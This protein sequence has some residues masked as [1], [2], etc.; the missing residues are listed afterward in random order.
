MIDVEQVVAGTLSSL[1]VR[2]D[3]RPRVRIETREGA[4]FDLPLE[5][6]ERLG[7]GQGTVVDE[8]ERER[9]RMLVRRHNAARDADT[10]LS[11]RL[12][13]RRELRRRLLAKGHEAA[14][15]D[16]L[17]SDLAERALL[18]DA[19]MARAFARDRIRLKPRGA[20]TI[21]AELR[22]RG[23]SPD[24][25]RSAVSQAFVDS[26]V[27]ERDLARSVADHWWATRGARSLERSGLRKTRERL[28]AHLA[29][30]GF[31]LDV[32]RLVADDVSACQD[33]SP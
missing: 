17:L 22:E 19:R 9:A 3:R 6:L 8:A 29:R 24:E 12:R 30:R 16:T 25:A 7:W 13:S 28:M 32:A 2:R 26:E 21:E 15:V 5:V 14:V 18:D 20:R 33:L 31:P 27:C 4:S 10:L 1:E 11:Y 23:V